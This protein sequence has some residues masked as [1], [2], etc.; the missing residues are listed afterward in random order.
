MSEDY[1]HIDI[2]ILATSVSGK[3]HELSAESQL[4]VANNILHQIDTHIQKTLELPTTVFLTSYESGCVRFEAVIR[5]PKKIAV[6]VLKKL[7]P[8]EISAEFIVNLI[9]QTAVGACVH[10]SPP[11][12]QEPKYLEPETF[13]STIIKAYEQEMFIIEV[14]K[15]EGFYSAVDRQLTTLKT[16]Y[17]HKTIEEIRQQVYLQNL[18]CFDGYNVDELLYGCNLKVSIPQH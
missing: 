2:S 17:P 12:V 15:G 14:Q 1:I 3:Y 11:I 5:I 6:K 10:L 18:G 16:I 8:A 9:I 13:R 7:H 4:F